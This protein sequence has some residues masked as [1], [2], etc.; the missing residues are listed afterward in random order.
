MYNL[1]KID[2]TNKSSKTT[3]S[4]DL[5]S[6]TSP[7]I[8]KYLIKRPKMIKKTLSLPLKNVSVNI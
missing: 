7:E 2:V 6:P 8:V 1:P 3:K 5:D 4:A